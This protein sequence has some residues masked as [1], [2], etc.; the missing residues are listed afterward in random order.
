MTVAVYALLAKLLLAHDVAAVT[1]AGLFL[2]LVGHLGHRV[3]DHFGNMRGKVKELLGG[4]AEQLASVN[5][6]LAAQSKKLDTAEQNIARLTTTIERKS[7][8]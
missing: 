4:H 1:L 6:A 7:V 5:T 2:A 3:V 8:F